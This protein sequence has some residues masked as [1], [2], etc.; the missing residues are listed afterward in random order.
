[1]CELFAISSAAA[2]AVRYS[3]HEFA[4]HGGRTHENKSGWGISFQQERDCLLIKEAMPADDSPWVE[5][6]ASQ[7]VKSHSVI[8]HVRRA[9]QSAPRFENTH[10]FQREMAG[11]AQV[12]AH[13]GTLSDVR[14]AL[15]LKD[16]RFLPIGETDS[17]HAFCYLLERLAPLW[18][19]G[20]P[21][22]EAR[23]EA[24]AETA[25]EL[26][27]IGSANFFYS[28]GDSLFLHADRRIYDEGGV[29]SAPKPPGLHWISR[30]EYRAKGLAVAKT[31]PLHNPAILVA[32]VPLNDDNWQGY[33][34]GTVAALRR[35][36][37]VGEI[38][39]ADGD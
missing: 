37:I 19:D 17:E 25:A 5:F 8:A 21:S 35:G 6:I 16:A 38:T 3:L 33:E 15:P 2:V 20:V 29:L 26:R 11:R 14:E 12:F 9:S 27:R 18:R 39:L 31:A 28:D 10:P 34:R 24:V 23:L 13:N 22:L 4:K 36:A 30:Q 7:P 1:V 32:S